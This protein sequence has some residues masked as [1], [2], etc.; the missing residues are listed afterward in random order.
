MT[1]I[2]GIFALA[3]GYFAGSLSSAVLVCRALGLPDPR[4][5]GSGNPGATNVLRMGHKQAAALTLLGDVL[6]GFMPVL[7]LR[8]CGFGEGVWALAGLGAF[9]G[10]LYPYFF[11]FKGGKGVATA[12]GVMLAAAP[13]LAL[14]CAGVWYYVFTKTRYSSLAAL[15]AA[16]SA[17]FISVLFFF[18]SDSR[19]HLVLWLM[20]AV[21]V[22]RHRDNIAR[23]KAG[24]EKAFEKI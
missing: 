20:I 10:H 7:L 19:F 11:Q 13:L 3:L 22:Y 16:A 1:F 23:L 24:E 12:F 17:P 14:C 18:Q 2:W 15:C 9:F 21:L 5:H 4:E 8:L 6:K